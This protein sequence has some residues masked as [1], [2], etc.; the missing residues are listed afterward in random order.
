M[1]QYFCLARAARKLPPQSSSLN[2]QQ[3]LLLEKTRACIYSLPILFTITRVSFSLSTLVRVRLLANHVQLEHSFLL[4]HP[5]RRDSLRIVSH[6]HVCEVGAVR[7]WF[8]L[9]VVLLLK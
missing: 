7:N 9:R 3:F 8:I 1:N 2:L 6:E 4:H 5:L